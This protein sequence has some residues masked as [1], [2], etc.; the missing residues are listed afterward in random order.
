MNFP[1]DLNPRDYEILNDP[2]PMKGEEV[3]SRRFLKHIEMNQALTALY[4]IVEVGRW[5]IVENKE[6]SIR[7]AFSMITRP[8]T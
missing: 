8:T 2:L 1:V 4:C 3:A 6:S 7:R 5:Q